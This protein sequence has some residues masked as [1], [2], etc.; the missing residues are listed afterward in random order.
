MSIV[1]VFPSA[2]LVLLFA[3]YLILMG[4]ILAFAIYEFNS[5]VAFQV[6]LLI[7]GGLLFAFLIVHRFFVLPKSFVTFLTDF[8]IPLVTDLVLVLI[9][10]G[11][12]LKLGAD[13]KTLRG[14]GLRVAAAGIVMAFVDIIPSAILFGY[15]CEYLLGWPWVLGALLGSMIGETSAAVVV[16]YLNHLIDLSSER[17]KKTE[18]LTK[19]TSVLK[20]E[21]TVNSVVLLLF[22]AIFYNQIY[23][24]NYNPTFTSFL[25]TTYSSLAG[26]VHYHLIVLLFVVAG[27]PAIVF[28]GSSIIVFFVKRRIIDRGRSKL[29]AYAVFS[30]N[31]IIVPKS[32]DSGDFSEKQLRMGMIL[33]GIVLGIAL[34]V[35]EEILSL[36]SFAGFA[37]VLFAL[38]GLIYLGFFIGYLFPGGNRLALDRETDKTGSRTFTGLMLFHDEFELL[39][40]I[41]FYFSIGVE[42]G[43]ML[44]NPPHGVEAISP[45]ELPGAVILMIAMGPIFLLLRYITGSAGLPVAFYSRYSGEGFRGDYRLVAAT[46]PKGVTVAAISVLILQTGI[47]FG[48]TI[49]VLALVAIIISTIGFT[50]ISAMGYKPMQARSPKEEIA[51]A[52]SEKP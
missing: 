34:L 49:Y 17:G 28:A 8:S 47:E 11:M 18:H 1:T 42:L 36:T 40:R 52:A 22:V 51:G 23:I 39:V 13:A 9:Y 29:K 48:S 6:I 2:S 37:N 20:L 21:S 38:L 33:Y 46:M 14:S 7:F 26:V 25:G 50:I 4:S 43:M 45:A 12:G 31:D 5:G 44:F 15:V 16:P 30:M 24:K 3:T 19:L 32:Q 41:V 27:I 10:A 35:F